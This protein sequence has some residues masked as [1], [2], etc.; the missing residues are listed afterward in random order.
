MFII[1]FSSEVTALFPTPASP[2]TAKL[3]SATGEPFTLLVD[4]SQEVILHVS[5]HGNAASQPFYVS[6]DDSLTATPQISV[7]E[8]DDLPV[9]CARAVRV[10]CASTLQGISS[11]L[12]K[13]LKHVR[14]LWLN[15][16]RCFEP[17]R[18]GGKGAPKVSPIRSL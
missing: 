14:Y 16:E 17:Y 10:N 2:I 7:S 13:E 15:S 9:S 18:C 11:E 1:V 12:F 8:L 6:T 5:L 4:S 3:L